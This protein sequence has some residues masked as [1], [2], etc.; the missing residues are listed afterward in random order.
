MAIK[1][2]SQRANASPATVS[3]IVDGAVCSGILQG[4]ERVTERHGQPRRVTF[5]VPVPAHSVV[6]S[7]AK[8]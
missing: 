2:V 5:H 6:V 4:I 3:R 7:R 8:R 1:D